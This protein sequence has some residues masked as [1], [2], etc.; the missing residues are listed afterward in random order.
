M[1]FLSWYQAQ[2][3]ADADPP[4]PAPPAFRT[5]LASPAGLPGSL[6]A[7]VGRRVT[8]LWR[9]G[10]AVASTTG[11]VVKAEGG[12]VEVRGAMRTFAEAVGRVFRRGPSV[13]ELNTVIPA[14]S[15]CALVEDVPRGLQ[16]AVPLYLPGLPRP[17]H[18]ARPTEHRGVVVDLAASRV[19][20]EA[21]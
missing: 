6:G 4:L 20:R 17:Q 10:P 18:D 7:Y 2:A 21:G 8:L 14:R 9:C 16:V 12:V 15:V 19:R 3:P 1:T 5:P 13:L 11:W